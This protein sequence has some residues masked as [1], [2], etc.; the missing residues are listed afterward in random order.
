VILVTLI[1]LTFPVFHSEN[2]FVGM[3]AGMLLR[4]RA[5]K[6]RVMRRIERIKVDEEI[7]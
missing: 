6:A 4:G 3:E 5:F 1:S 7:P 2:L